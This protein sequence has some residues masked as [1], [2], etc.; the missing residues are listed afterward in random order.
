MTTRKRVLFSLAAGLAVL[1]L[2]GAARPG[3]QP[4]SQTH[5]LMAE[6]SQ[7]FESA[8]DKGNDFFKRFFGANPQ[9]QART[10]RSLGSG[11]IVSADGHILTNNHVVEGAQKLTV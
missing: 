10:V 6:I 5:A 2:A 3:S 9:P 7:A 11:V 4:Q 8:A 1:A